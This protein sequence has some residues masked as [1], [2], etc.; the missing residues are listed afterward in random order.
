MSDALVCALAQGL[1]VFVVAGGSPGRKQ[2]PLHAEAHLQVTI[3]GWWSQKM[4]FSILLHIIIK[5][6]IR[7]QEFPRLTHSDRFQVKHFKEKKTDIP[8]V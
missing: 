6:G 2:Q 4:Q 8:D 5:K 1:I 3:V 7:R